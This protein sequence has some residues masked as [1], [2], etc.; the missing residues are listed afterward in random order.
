MLTA[1]SD[2][3]IGSFLAVLKLLGPAAGPLSFPMEGYTLALDFPASS[4]SFDLLRELDAIVADYGG[5]L[6][7]TKDACTG[8][9]MLRGYKQLEAFRTVRD[10]V[11][12]QHRFRSLQSE[13][14]GL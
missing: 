12:P 8:S 7:L 3:G 13:R 2:R 4:K 11:D 1:I 9:S 14:L 10:R 6:Y 5:R